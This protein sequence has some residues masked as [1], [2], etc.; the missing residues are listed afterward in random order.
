MMLCVK[1]AQKIESIY[2]RG[3]DTTKTFVVHEKFKY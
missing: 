1:E 2:K 3:M